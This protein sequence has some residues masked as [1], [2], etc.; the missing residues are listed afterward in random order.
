MVKGSIDSPPPPRLPR[1]PPCAAASTRSECCSQPKPT[2]TTNKPAYCA[3][4]LLC[5]EYSRALALVAQQCPRADWAALFSACA[6]ETCCTEVEYH[7]ASGV[8]AGAGHNVGPAWPAKASPLADREA[9]LLGAVL[10]AQVRA[11]HVMRQS[12]HCG[13][14]TVRQ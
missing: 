10:A 4:G 13:Q 6:K 9:F 11:A 8:A 7:Q 14:R 1:L 3:H 12:R 2:P 5:R